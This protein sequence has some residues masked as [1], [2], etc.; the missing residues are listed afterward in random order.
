MRDPTLI[1]TVQD[2]HGS[3]V[4]VE[5]TSETVTG[6]SFV[7][8]EGYRIGQVGSFVRIP[9]GF[10][11]LFGVVSQVGAGAAPERD[12]NRELYGNR[13]LRVQLVGEGTRGGHFE[14]GVSQHPTID[15]RVHIV[16]EADLR[17]IYGPGEPDDFVAVGHLASAE[18]IPALIDINKLVTRHA[19]V[20]GTTGAGKSTTVAGLLTSLSEGIRYPSSRI[21]VLDI[22]GE[23]AKALAD[24]STVFRV[25]ADVAKG[26]RMLQVPFWALS[27]D[28]LV[29]LALGNLNDSQASVVAD[30]IV[31]LKKESLKNPLMVSI[32]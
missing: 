14:R 15:D 12:D 5:L 8:G 10:V 22:H 2:V 13:W 19:A 17:A 3:T 26:G 28:E 29:A 4:T 21:V 25:S 9:L 32:I 18:S 16:T 20:V 27:F 6:L 7:N 1:G 31:A 11:D 24:R 23:Y 30:L